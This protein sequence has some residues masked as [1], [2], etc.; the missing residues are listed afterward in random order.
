MDTNTILEN[1][2]YRLIGKMQAAIS[3]GDIKKAKRINRMIDINQK[4]L[5][6]MIGEKHE[7][8]H[9]VSPARK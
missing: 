7:R 1:R 6:K 9:L 4:S 3:R 2:F 5:I 8:L